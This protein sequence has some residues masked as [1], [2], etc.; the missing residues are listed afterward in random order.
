M[1]IIGYESSEKITTK[2]G[3]F[4]KPVLKIKGWVDKPKE[5]SVPDLTAT[6]NEESVGLSEDDI[7]F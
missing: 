7:P 5:L 3:N 1:P 6:E 4:Y 2:N